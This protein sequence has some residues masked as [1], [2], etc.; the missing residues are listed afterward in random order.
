VKPEEFAKNPIAGSYAVLGELSGILPQAQAEGRTRGVLVSVGNPR[1][2]QTVALGGFL[3]QA[4]LARSYP[5]NAIEQDNGAMLVLQQGPGD[6]L[7]AGSALRVTVSNDPERTSVP[8]G[9]LSVEE[10]VI[11]NGQWRTLTRPN[12]DEDNQGHTLFLAAHRFTLL[13]VRV[14]QLAQ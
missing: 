12:G 5:A 1:A 2:S 4:S 9:I 3:F 13:R 11:E 10:G 8:A 6:F 7:I 14:Y